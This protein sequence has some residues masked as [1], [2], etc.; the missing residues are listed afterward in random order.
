MHFDYFCETSLSL[1]PT[2]RLILI[3]NQIL[4][5]DDKFPPNSMSLNNINI[6]SKFTKCCFRHV[7]KEIIFYNSFCYFISME[8]KFV[9]G[10]T[11]DTK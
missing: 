2:L 10:Y 11:E 6:Q 3:E 7:N 5:K 9:H 1:N 8:C 4:F